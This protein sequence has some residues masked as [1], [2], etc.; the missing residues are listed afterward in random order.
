MSRRTATQRTLIRGASQ[1][2]TCGA[3]ASDPVGRIDGGAVLIEDG[4]IVAVGRLDDVEAETVIDAGGHVVMPGF[5]DCHTHVVFGGTRVDEYA[6]G[7]AG[8]PVPDGAPV[9]ILGTM[10]ATRALDAP[11]LAEAAAPRLAQM[12]THGTTTVESKTGYGLARD[13]ELAMLHANRLLAQRGGGPRIVSTYLGAHAL[14]PDSERGAYVDEVCETIPEIARAGLASFCD[15]YCDE[16]YF[17]VAE[18]RRI[19]ECGLAHGLA[20]KLHLDAYS[21]TGAA[22]LATEL[23]A[24]SVDHLN[25]TRPQEIEALARSGVVGVVMP[26]LEF[27]VA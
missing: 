11:A 14:P 6:A 19:L 4:R 3:D 18:G 15:V 9:G 23:G 13:A 22:A 24:V 25:H 16:G 10:N 5:V 26:L 7:C 1:V 21:H 27:A 12:L 17:T 20:P 8:E 2:L